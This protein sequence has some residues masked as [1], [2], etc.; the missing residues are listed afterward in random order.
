MEKHLKVGKFHLSEPFLFLCCMFLSNTHA[1]T[2]SLSLSLSL[3]AGVACIMYEWCM[4]GRNRQVKCVCVCVCAAQCDRLVV[5]SQSKSPFR[6]VHGLDR[7]LEKRCVC[8]STSVVHSSSPPV[9]ACCSESCMF[10]VQFIQA[11]FTAG[12]LI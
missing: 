7:Y 1:R 3:H 9:C 8:S 6:Q 12:E 2:L 11:T 10:V 4:R 5:D